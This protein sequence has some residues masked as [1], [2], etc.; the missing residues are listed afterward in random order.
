MIFN[1]LIEITTGLK[2]LS[3]LNIKKTRA[4][5]LATFF[6]SFGGFSIHMQNMA[7]LNKYNINYYIYLIARIIHGS[8]SSLLVFFILIYYY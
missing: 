5:A 1:G 2:Y 7:I 4:I 8:L 3:I 6:I